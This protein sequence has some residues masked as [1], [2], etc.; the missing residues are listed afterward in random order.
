MAKKY[1]LTSKSDMRRFQK[2]M[3]KQLF[4]SIANRLYDV[5][6]PHCQRNV[7]VKPGL[8]PCPMCREEIDLHINIK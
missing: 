6:C 1:K 3:E 4:D 5:Q 2:D 8:S 7:R